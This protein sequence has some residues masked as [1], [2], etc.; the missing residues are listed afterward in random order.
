MIPSLGG[1]A[2]GSQRHP[3][4][5][6]IC[7]LLAQPEARFNGNGL[8]AA[9]IFLYR[10]RST[11]LKQCPHLQYPLKSG[12][13]QPEKR[14]SSSSFANPVEAEITMALVKATTS[15]SLIWPNI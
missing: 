10:A 12:F 5:P 6:F 11:E 15:P 7:P 3:G 1:G 8:G 9:V 2:F 14:V 4:A 13:C